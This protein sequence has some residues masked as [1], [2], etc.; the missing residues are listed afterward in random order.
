MLGFK[1]C[2]DLRL[3]ADIGIGTS[4]PATGYYEVSRCIFGSLNGKLSTLDQLYL[5]QA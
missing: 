4:D 1:E 3:D 5:D 2:G